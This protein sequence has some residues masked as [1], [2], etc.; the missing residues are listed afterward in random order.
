M[1]QMKDTL[2][3]NVRSVRGYGDYYWSASLGIAE[4]R[5]VPARFFGRIVQNN[6]EVMRDLRND[7]YIKEWTPFVSADMTP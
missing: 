6:S 5:S 7:L 4:D 1:H 3:I 2:D